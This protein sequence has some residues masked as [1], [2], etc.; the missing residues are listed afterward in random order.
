MARVSQPDL[1]LEDNLRTPSGVS[2]MMENRIIG[3]RVLPEF[4]ER[5]R[6]RRSTTTRPSS[7]KPSGI[8]LRADAARR[9]QLLPGRRREYQAGMRPRTAGEAPQVALTVL[10]QQ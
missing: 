1:V 7:S 4:V 8:S 5:Y 6:V 3:R 9:R 10:R 2:Y